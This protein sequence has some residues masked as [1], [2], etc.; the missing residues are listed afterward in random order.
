MNIENI[1]KIIAKLQEKD[2]NVLMMSSWCKKIRLPSSGECGTAA[3]IGGWAQIIMRQEDVNYYSPRAATWMGIDYE[4]FLDLCFMRRCDFDHYW[5]DQE[6]D[7]PTSK[8]IGVRALEILRD[9]GKVDWGRAISE[10]T[11]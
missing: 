8:K 7:I 4:L 9:E 1:N 10:I 5:F 11:A 6:Y 3:C 2:T